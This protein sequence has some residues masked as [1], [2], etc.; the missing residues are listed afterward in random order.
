MALKRCDEEN[1]SSK[2]PSKKTK[3]SIDILLTTSMDVFSKI[4]RQHQIEASRGQDSEEL[5]Y[6]SM[7]Q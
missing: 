6:L 4:S 2:E 1:L 5:L 7:L 3:K